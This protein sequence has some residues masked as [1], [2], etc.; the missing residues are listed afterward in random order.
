MFVI[1]QKKFLVIALI[2]VF[3]VGVFFCLPL[4]YTSAHK[5]DYTVVLDAGHGG[6]DGGVVGYNGTIEKEI[7]LKYT[8]A[9]KKLLESNNIGVI[10]TRSDDDGLYDTNSNNKKLS[11]MSVRQEIIENTQPDLVVSIHMNSF[12]LKSVY[13]ANCFYG[14]NNEH[15]K[16]VANYIQRLFS[17]NLNSKNSLAKEGDYFI[18]N[19]TQYPSVLVEC[20][21]LSNP[22]EEALLNS[23]EYQNKLLYHI[24][25]GMVA[26]LG[27]TK[28]VTNI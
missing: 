4:R 10:L 20:G 13:G 23:D 12:P 18:L 24:Y 28:N 17:K 3:C 22:T 19:C 5:L 25:C 9:L 1:I 14:L 27:T 8:L 26:F 11:D 21:F 15:G 7:N 2:C 16:Q 6:R